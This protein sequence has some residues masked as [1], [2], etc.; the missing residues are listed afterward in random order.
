MPHVN[1]SLVHG[2]VDVTW[3][4]NSDTWLTKVWYCLDGNEAV[5]G[6][7]L[8]AENCSFRKGWQAALIVRTEFWSYNQQNIRRENLKKKA[9]FPTST[10]CNI[11]FMLK[12]LQNVSCHVS[13]FYRTEVASLTLLATMCRPHRGPCHAI[14]RRWAL[15]FW[16]L[17]KYE[18]ILLSHY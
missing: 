13:H 11:L 12:I 5:W 9:A 7:I 3:K 16:N 4:F 6:H 1:L 18:S 8:C 14:Q 2:D 17:G 15:I 10:M